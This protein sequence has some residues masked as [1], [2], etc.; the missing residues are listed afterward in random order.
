MSERIDLAA[1]ETRLK[2]DPESPEMAALVATITRAVRRADVA[3]EASGGSSRHWTRECFLPEMR[4]VDLF[5]FA[6]AEF[7]S[8]LAHSRAETARA[9]KAAPLLAALREI[10][11]SGS[12]EALAAL[13]VD[14]IK[15]YPE[16]LKACEIA[17]V[18]EIAAREKAEADP[19][20]LAT[21]LA[22]L[23]DATATLDEYV[24]NGYGSEDPHLSKLSDAVW[25]IARKL[26]DVPVTDVT[27]DT[28]TEGGAA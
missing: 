7:S 13:V 17:V 27:E 1:I 11:I 15:G 22:P 10:G 14:A 12:G 2:V 23:L 28:D 3:F 9:D 26:A 25:R 8:I 4:A 6:G 20:A 24:C 16:R 19:A 5:V 21:S 18:R